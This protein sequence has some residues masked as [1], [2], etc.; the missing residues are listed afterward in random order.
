MSN[1]ETSPP[2]TVIPTNASKLLR[3]TQK[4]IG[5]DDRSALLVGE[6]TVYETRL[7]S[8]LAFN[9]LVFNLALGSA[10]MSGVLRKRRNPPQYAKAN[11]LTISSTLL[12]VFSFM[13]NISP[14]FE[15]KYALDPREDKLTPSGLKK[16]QEKKKELDEKYANFEKE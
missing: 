2:A 16:W 8:P 7:N 1:N 4:P 5:P 14:S 11:I 15:R 13:R 6:R 10:Y 3:Q 9:I 12:L